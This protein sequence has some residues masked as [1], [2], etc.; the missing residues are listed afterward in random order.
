MSVQFTLGSFFSP[1]EDRVQLD[2]AGPREEAEDPAK[3]S[4]SEPSTGLGWAWAM[5]FFLDQL[6]KLSSEPEGFNRGENT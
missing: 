3:P 1:F 2:L 5:T 4:P 6:A